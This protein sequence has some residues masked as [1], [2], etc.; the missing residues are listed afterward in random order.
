MVIEPYNFSFVLF[1]SEVTQLAVFVL[2]VNFSLKPFFL[3]TSEYIGIELQKMFSSN[4]I[5][6][7]RLAI[8]FGSCFRTTG[9]W[10]DFLMM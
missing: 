10:L 7:I 1:F 4:E 3:S 8:D 6:D 9:G 2:Y 5:S